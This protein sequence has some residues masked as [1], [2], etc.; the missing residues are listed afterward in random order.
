MLEELGKSIQGEVKNDEETLR[1]YSADAS[2]FEVRPRAVVF[3]KNAEDILSLVRFIKAQNELGNKVSLTARGK[4]TDLTGAPLNEG[5]VVR[6][7][8]YIEGIIETGEDFVRVEPG[9]VYGTLQEHL[10]PAGRWIPVNPASGKFCSV[11]GMVSNNSGGTKSLKYGTTRKHVKSLKLVFADGSEI[12]TS[13]HAS[14]L[15]S[16]QFKELKLLLENHKDLIT[17][18]TPHVTKN[19]SGYALKEFLET[20]DPAQLFLGSEGTLGIV[21][22]ITF[23]TSE[24]PSE[25]GVVLGYFNDL[26]QAGEAVLRLLPLGPCALE[27]VD[28]HVIDIVR[29]LQPELTKSVPQPSPAI[30]LFCEFD[31]SEEEIQERFSK[32]MPIMQELAFQTDQALKPPKE[33]ALWQLRVKSAQVMEHMQGNK[34]T[35]PLEIDAAVPVESFPAYIEGTYKIF[36]DFDFQFAVWGHA[37]DANLHIRPIIDITSEQERAK[38][39]LLAKSMYELVGRLSGTASGEH[40]D[41][42]LSTPFLSA[43]QGQEILDVYAK[44]KYIFDPMG[45]LNPMKKVGASVEDF[46]RFLRKDFENYYKK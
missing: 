32:A 14:I 2:I 20:G 5:I 37:G 41:G 1:H 24:K 18:R 27:M 6:F 39:S 11:G 21:K 31:G 46:N 35:V 3:P 26:K 16:P 28:A 42:L 19:S 9:I 22:E 25:E 29:S 44:V 23:S 34:R 4:G 13:N 38:L 8:G 7:S 30:M 43:I 33:D 12:D 17:S 40:G 45:M 15:E 10:G 36:E